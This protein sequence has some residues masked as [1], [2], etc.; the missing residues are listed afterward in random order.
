MPSYEDVPT[1][2]LLKQLETLK[3][4]E[5][6]S[7]KAILDAWMGLGSRLDELRERHVHGLLGKGTW[8]QWCSRHGFV[9]RWVDRWIE[10][11]RAPHPATRLDEIL[12][13]DAMMTPDEKREKRGP[14]AI[15]VKRPGVIFGY[16]TDLDQPTRR[17]FWALCNRMY[18]KE[19][20]QVM[21][22]VGGADY[23]DDEDRP[24]KYS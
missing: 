9:K 18:R 12:L 14:H 20:R 8:S 15:I 1:A 17:E 2:E 6:T 23:D 10:V 4:T 11:S 7:R 13:Y 24:P 22:E 19:M 21:D 16:V 3:D 5:F